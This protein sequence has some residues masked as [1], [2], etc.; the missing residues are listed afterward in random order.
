IDEQVGENIELKK[1]VEVAWNLAHEPVMLAKEFDTWLVIKPTGI[2]MT[3]LLAKNG[4]LKS[5]IGINGYTQTVTSAARHAVVT[6][7][8]LP[9]LKIVDKVSDNFRIS[10]MSPVSYEEAGRQATNRFTGEKF[11]FL[12]RKYS[13]EVTSI[14]MYGQ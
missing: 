1:S 11:S 13:V 4:V 2:V 9:D 3:P 12:G 6:A 7:P 10:L 5:V 8:R 14:E